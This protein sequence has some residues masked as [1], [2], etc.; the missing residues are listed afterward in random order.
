MNFLTYLIIKLIRIYRFLISPLLGD[1]CRYFP[2]CSDYSIESLR[3]YGLLKGLLLSFKR[4]L[5]CHPWCDG[6][7]DP[8]KKKMKVKK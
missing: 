5:S 4:I 7:L 3:T 8:V 1:S 2:T 6:G